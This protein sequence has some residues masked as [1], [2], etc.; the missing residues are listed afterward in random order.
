MEGH[1]S[2]YRVAPSLRVCW[3]FWESGGGEEEGRG[4]FAGE[5]EVK[6]AIFVVDQL[7]CV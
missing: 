3:N 5:G 6:S 2:L 1:G 7:S 4:T